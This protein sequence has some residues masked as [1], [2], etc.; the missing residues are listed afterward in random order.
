MEYGL[1]GLL[2]SG[3]IK[4]LRGKN[5]MGH[6]HK[7]YHYNNFRFK[8]NYVL[9]VIILLIAYAF[10]SSIYYKFVTSIFINPFLYWA[11]VIAI[12]LY[13]YLRKY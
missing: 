1:Y 12:S 5:K 9:I 4:E 10:Y 7:H 6:H 3:V 11:I 8:T 13:V 2:E